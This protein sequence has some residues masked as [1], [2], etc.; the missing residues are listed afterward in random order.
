MTPTLSTLNL[1][2]FTTILMLVI[3]GLICWSDR[4]SRHFHTLEFWFAYLTYFLF[5]YVT[6]SY[7]PAIVALSCVLWIW[8]TKTI[9]CI[10]SDVVKANLWKNW[11]T[12]GLVTGYTVGVLLYFAGLEFKFF[13]MPPAVANFMIGVDIIYQV[14]KRQRVKKDFKIPH[15]LLI[16]NVL[17]ISIHLL[18]YP[19]IRYDH[20]YTG[21]GFAVVLLTTIL[22]AIVL[23]AV[24]YSDLE[25]SYK[26]D[27]EN[28]LRQRV[29]QLTEQSKYS[30]LGEVTAGI[31]HEINHPMSI[32]TDRAGHLRHQVLKNQASKDV[33]MK[34]LDQIEITSE[35]M[36]K[37]IN[38]LRKFSEYSEN[39]PLQVVA[40]A[41]VVEDTLSYCSDRFHQANILLDVEPYPAVDIECRSTQISQVLLNL[42]NNSFDAIQLKKNPWVRIVFEEEKASVKIKVI[43]SGSGIQEVIRRKIFEP[44][45]STKVDAGSTGLGLSLSKSMVESHKGRLFYDETSANTCFVVEVPYRQG[46]T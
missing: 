15:K 32:I 42:L 20:T 9:V 26:E 7:G 25:K 34:D 14:V 22:M 23:P 39:E 8:R 6:Q 35:R 19:F 38:S 28:I 16:F 24:S 44:F 12:L 33:L 31:I 4:N 29:K 17:I 18:D 43:D 2:I 1:A 46:S 45:F 10:V 30:A 3:N 36:N 37:V 5:S 13:T 41:T 40:V 11:H 21:I 27:V